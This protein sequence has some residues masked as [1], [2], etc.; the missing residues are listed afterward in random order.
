MMLFF[1]DP[2][3]LTYDV[4]AIQ[5]PWRNSEFFTTYH[6]HK[7][8]FHLI[9]IDHVLTRVCFYINKRLDIS[10]WHATHHN[11]DLCSIHLEIHN[12]GRLHI[13]NI[14]NP[15]LS[16]SSQPGQVPKFEQA[17]AQFPSNKHIILGD[18]NLHHPV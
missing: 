11:S 12:L 6:P 5:E 3:I 9:Y 2:R 18:F 17:I 1:D 15:V 7:D 16:T 4:I 10:S 8:I 13:H 14:Y